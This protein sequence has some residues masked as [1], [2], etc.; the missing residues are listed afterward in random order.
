M[1]RGGGE[2]LHWPPPLPAL[3]AIGHIFVNSFS[4]YDGQAKTLSKKGGQ[5]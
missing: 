2:Y 1:I 5:F 3:Y 4:A